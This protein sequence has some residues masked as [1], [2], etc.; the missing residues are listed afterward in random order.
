MSAIRHVVFPSTLNNHLNLLNAAIKL[1]EIV[2]C[3]RG[4]GDLEL[5]GSTLGAPDTLA[6][7]SDR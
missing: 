5:L 6:Q 7:H 4:G 3:K 2:S 1:G